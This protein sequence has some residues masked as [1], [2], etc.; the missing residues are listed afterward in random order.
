[1]G[2]KTTA[3]TG[4]TP[5]YVLELEMAAGE[6]EAAAIDKLFRIAKSMYNALLTE[7]WKRLRALKGDKAY[8]EGV[9][10]AQRLS[11]ERTKLEKAL[12]KA[13]ANGDGEA[14]ALLRNKLSAN[15]L[16]R[17]ACS[18]R[19]KGIQMAHGFSEYQ[20]HEHAAKVKRHFEKR[21]PRKGGK[22]TKPISPLGINETQKLASRAFA[23]VER[24]L[25]GKA[26]TARFKGWREGMSVEN[27]SNSS[28]LRHKGGAHP[29]HHRKAF[30]LLRA[31]GAGGQGEVRTR[32]KP[33]GQGR[34]AL[35]CAA[36]DGG[37]AA[38][39]RAARA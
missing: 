11:A 13:L 16:A 6:K 19:L 24:M 32:H 15:T 20:L 38:R 14:R 37:R 23:A 25:Y 8:R 28:G 30:R 9:R 34:Y 22:G 39:E 18:A 31:R 7:A 26:H 33:R 27:K 35:L 4:R 29:A 36:S 1:M 2:T 17:K 12:G 3:K 5:S 21:V 10:E